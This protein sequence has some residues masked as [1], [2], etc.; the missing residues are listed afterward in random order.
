MNFK[1]PANAA[2][3]ANDSYLMS[4]ILLG[5]WSWPA[6]PTEVCSCWT[7]Q[8]GRSS[9]SFHRTSGHAS[10]LHGAC[11]QTNRC[12][13]ASLHGCSVP[14]MSK[15]VDIS[16]PAVSTAPRPRRRGG[17]RRPGT[18]AKLLRPGPA[19]DSP[20]SL[21]SCKICSGKVRSRQSIVLRASSLKMLPANAF[22]PLPQ[23]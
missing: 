17:R 18:H 12:F 20:H 23:L 14:E 22:N 11:H 6:C 8:T 21:R 7:L 16:C 1:H 13:R 4:S 2:Y 15:A 3:T 5:Q 9:V 10:E 19:K